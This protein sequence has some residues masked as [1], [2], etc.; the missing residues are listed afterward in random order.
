[1]YFLRLNLERNRE[2]V[3]KYYTKDYIFN[4]YDDVTDFVK[5]RDELIIP[6]KNALQKWIQ[7][8]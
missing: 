3:M 8:K 7:E 4:F 5:R 2:L 6:G 1:M